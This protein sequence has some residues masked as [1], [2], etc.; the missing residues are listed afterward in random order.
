MMLAPAAVGWAARRGALRLGGTRLAFFEKSPVAWTLTALAANELI[1]DQTKL[2]PHRTEPKSLVGR[3]LSG[4][5]SGAAIGAGRRGRSL[6]GAA[7][8]ATGALLG[9]F[10]GHALRA[11]L[12]RALGRDRPA[13][14]LE[15]AVAIV[16]V[17]AA[18]WL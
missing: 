18:L 12:A 17:L 6:S 13:A 3:L 11:R 9:A 8:G 14:L 2:L 1:L 4:A 16:G 7:L 15:D 10:G 5:L